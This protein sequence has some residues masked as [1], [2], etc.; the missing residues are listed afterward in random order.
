MG[1]Y[2][3]IYSYIINYFSNN[4][5]FNGFKVGKSSNGFKIKIKTDYINV[6]NDEVMGWH[7]YG[8]I[9]DLNIA[10]ITENDLELFLDTLNYSALKY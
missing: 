9:D 1:N 5:Y 6:E 7:C 3:E 8:N 2:N 10:K 4:P